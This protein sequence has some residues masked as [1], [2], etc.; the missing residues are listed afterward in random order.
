MTSYLKMAT[1]QEKAMC[2]LRFFETKSVIKTQRRYRT[3]YGKDPPSDKQM[4]SYT[5]NAGEH[6]EEN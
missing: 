1:V 3:Q 5:A 6:L 2:I 4:N